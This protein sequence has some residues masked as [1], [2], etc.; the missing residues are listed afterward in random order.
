V[1]PEADLAFS[2]HARKGGA[3][4]IARG[5]RIVAVLRGAAAQRFLAKVEPA[6]LEER[7]QLMARATGNYRRGNE[8]SADAPALDRG[9]VNG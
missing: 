3:V 9:K 1:K 6:P 5:G 4:A 7:Q 8:R 2:F